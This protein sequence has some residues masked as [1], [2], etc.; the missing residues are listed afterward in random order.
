MP[1][2][3]GTKERVSD[4][5]DEDM[6]RVETYCGFQ[7]DMEE[8]REGEREVKQRVLRAGQHSGH[9]EYLDYNN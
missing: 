1:R 4:M 9:T 3:L 7:L 6:K 2:Q 5:S 8:E